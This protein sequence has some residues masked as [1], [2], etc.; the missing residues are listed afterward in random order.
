MA[1]IKGPFHCDK[2]PVVHGH[3]DAFKNHLEGHKLSEE[4]MVPGQENADKV[5]IDGEIFLRCHK[6]D[7]V[8]KSEYDSYYYNHM[9]KYHQEEN[10]CEDCGKKFNNP[11]RLRRHKLV[12]HTQYPRDCEECGKSCTSS[13]DY[14][15][16]FKEAHD[17]GD[18]QELF[19]CEICARIVKGK[20]GLH[21]H[22]KHM[23]G[24]EKFT[25]TE[26]GKQYKSKESLKYHMAVAHLGEY[27][28]RCDECGKGYMVEKKMIICKNNHA[29]IFNY[30]CDKCDFKTNDQG[31][32]KKHIPIHS[33][34]KLFSCPLCGYRCTHAGR[35]S[36]HI[37]KV[38]KST[39][40]EV[41]ITTKIS[42][43]GEPLTEAEIEKLKTTREKF[44]K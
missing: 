36:G 14:L 43:L 42:R 11:G 40:L 18:S 7:L 5:D 31:T 13:S 15:E 3:I 37:K 28:F 33:D 35:L 6:C 21:M 27:K 29:G 16:H 25:C 23:H 2:C 19:T 1:D 4:H 10:I 17:I 26:C 20:V 39:L 30:K 38:H 44:T 32:F 22:K 9:K 24:N 8:F 34:V 12:L 41:E